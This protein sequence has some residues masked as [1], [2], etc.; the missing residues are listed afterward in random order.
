MFLRELEF[1]PYADDMASVYGAADLVLSR[2]GASTVAE[3]R[4]L[5]LP[6]ILVPYPHSTGNHQLFN[7]KLLEK[8]GQ[9]M[10][11]RDEELSS[12]NILKILKSKLLRKMPPRKVESAQ[13]IGEV[14]LNL[15]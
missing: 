15:A 2:A 9:A 3:L 4:A 10:V 5:G 11:I 8:D 6:A 14:V 1:L 12:Q 13:A 7:A